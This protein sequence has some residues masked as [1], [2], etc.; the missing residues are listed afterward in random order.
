MVD[1]HPTQIVA[2][3]REGG[4]NTLVVWMI[5]LDVRT[6]LIS[7]VAP[8]TQISSTSIE[9]RCRNHLCQSTAILFVAP[10]L[11]VK[12][13]LLGYILGDDVVVVR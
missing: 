13:L 3:I 1:G 5:Q 9:H 2:D 10:T 4:E 8:R 11:D 7:L 6:M 12:K